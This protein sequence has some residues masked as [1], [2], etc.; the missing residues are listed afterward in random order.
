MSNLADAF[1][2]TEETFIVADKSIKFTFYRFTY[3][4]LKRLNWDWGEKCV[5]Q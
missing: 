1:V 4:N 5:H 2:V 3:F